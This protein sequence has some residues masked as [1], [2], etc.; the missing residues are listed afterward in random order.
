MNFIY[1]CWKFSSNLLN[2]IYLEIS[3]KLHPRKGKEHYD[4][5]FFTK[6]V[7]N[8]LFC[9]VLFFYLHFAIK[10]VLNFQLIFFFYVIHC[11]K[12]EPFTSSNVQ[13][14]KKIFFSNT[15]A[16]KSHQSVN[17]STISPSPNSIAPDNKSASSLYYILFVCFS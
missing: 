10:K 2:Y 17:T 8:F 11:S 5:Y 13:K 15:M 3:K 7:A 4:Y 14:K 9:F 16:E 1:C 12:P 6:F